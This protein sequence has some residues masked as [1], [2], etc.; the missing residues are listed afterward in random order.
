MAAH[1]LG[2][3]L[4]PFRGRR[5]VELAS[6]D[7][8]FA[9]VAVGETGPLCELFYRYGDRVR[10]VVAQTGALDDSTLDQAVLLS[11]LEVYRLAA[12][13]SGDTKV[14]SWIVAVALEATRRCS[15]ATA[16]REVTRT[17]SWAGRGGRRPRRASR[18]PVIAA[19]PLSSRLA[20]VLVDGEGVRVPDVAVVLGCTERTVWRRLDEA[21]RWLQTASAYGRRLQSLNRVRRFLRTGRLCPARWKLTRAV[22]T[23][24][25]PRMGWHLSG[26][27]DCE[28]EYVSLLSLTARLSL[29]SRGGMTAASRDRVAALLLAA[30]RPPTPVDAT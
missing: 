17:N 24:L 7:A 15:D 12:R 18:V 3:K 21:H 11:F 27:S 9:D 20:L 10:R 1:N 13:F 6:D 28:R 14:S 26:C 2:G 16:P 22:C 5:A 19:L 29:L 25:D 8:L 30:N 4:L 23:D